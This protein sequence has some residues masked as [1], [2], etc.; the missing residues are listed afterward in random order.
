MFTLEK[1]TSFSTDY[2]SCDS[3]KT[4][5]HKKISQVSRV[6]STWNILKQKF[7]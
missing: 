6:I 3:G 1:G 5:Q 7:Y 4:S 2:T